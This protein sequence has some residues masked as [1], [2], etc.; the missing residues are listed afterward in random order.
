MGAEASFS[1]RDREEFAAGLEGRG[2]AAQGL[3]RD[4]LTEMPLLY[5]SASAPR[6]DP[7]IVLA[8]LHREEMVRR[9]GGRVF[10]SSGK[11]S[12]VSL[13]FE[14]AMTALALIL[15]LWALFGKS[16]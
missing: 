2:R 7:G 15:F 11:G 14:R 10:R 5:G 12:D 9:H 6:G 13:P 3:E 8:R 1:D 4:L 16:H